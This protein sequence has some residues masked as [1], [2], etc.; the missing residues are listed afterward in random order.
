LVNLVVGVFSS[1]AH[2]HTATAWQRGSRARALH[3]AGST[4]HTAAHCS[5]RSV[6]VRRHADRVAGEVGGQ[7]HRM[8]AAR[9]ALEMVWFGRLD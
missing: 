6:A 4:P 5:A 9:C 2:N 8:V 7:F 3:S 1:S